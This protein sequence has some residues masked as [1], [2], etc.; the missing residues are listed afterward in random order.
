MVLGMTRGEA[1]LVAFI[2]C[3]IYF[4]AYVPRVGRLVGGLFSRR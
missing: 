4:A 2:F 1:A 3:L